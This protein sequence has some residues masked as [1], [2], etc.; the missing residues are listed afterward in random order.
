MVREVRMDTSDKEKYVGDVIC[1]DAMLKMGLKDRISKGIGIVVQLTSL[2]DQ[3]SLGYHYFEIAIKLREALFINGILYNMEVWYGLK[4]S[5]IKEIEA[6]DE[7][8][9]RK[10]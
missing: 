5:D 4:C 7:M 2:L 3:V 10:I 8:F 6:I 1:N 9:L